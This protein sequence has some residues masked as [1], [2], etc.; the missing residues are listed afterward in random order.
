MEGVVEDRLK[1]VESS[2]YEYDIGM[3]SIKHTRARRVKFII[4]DK[5][6]KIPSPK[7]EDADLEASTIGIFISL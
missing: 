3:E 6:L 7:L 5:Y 4:M 2:I 1:G